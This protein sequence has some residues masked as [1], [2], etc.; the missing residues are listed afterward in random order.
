M[1]HFSE[2]RP[3]MK[4]EIVSA[5]TQDYLR[6][7]G[8]FCQST[9]RPMVSA[10]KGSID[11]AVLVHGLGG[12]FYSSRLLFHFAETLMDLGVSV[13]VVNTRG[14]E[15][16][17][18]TPW[19]GRSQSVGAALE[20]VD[21]CRY[22]LN[23]WADFL[24]NRGYGHVLF[25]GH[26]LGAIKSLYAQAHEPHAKVRSI[27]GLSATRLSYRKLIDRSNGELFRETIARSQ[28][29]IEEGRGHNPIHVKFPFPTWMT[30]QCYID[31]YG[32]EEK[33]NWMNFI[34]K[35]TI[36]TLMMF[37]AKELADDP[38][39]A[40]VAEELEPLKR[41]W[42]SLTIETIEDADHFYTSKFDEVDDLITRWLT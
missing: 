12:N 36:P 3:T 24:V 22:D 6:L 4:G 25:F 33:F 13:V 14:H 11:A 26:S 21:H 8:L 23:A 34:D 19:A 9:E 40:G 31:K 35:V 2:R 7:H 18:T 29:L 16:I 27:I 37:G 39:F 1:D 30:P 32:P 10:E 20:N 41:G 42:N 28:T 5:T 15:M 38:A 17:N